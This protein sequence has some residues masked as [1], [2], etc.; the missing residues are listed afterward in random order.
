MMKTKLA[1]LLATLAAAFLIGGAHPPKAHAY[2]CTGAYSH[3]IVIAME[4]H[5]RSE[6]FG[7]GNA[8]YLDSLAAQYA[9]FSNY[10]N[11]IHP[12]L[13]NYL[14]VTGGTTGGI[15]SDCLPSQC[16]A[17]NQNNIFH[18]LNA[19]PNLT[20]PWRVEAESMPSNCYKTDSGN[21]YPKHNP[22]VYYTDLGNCST[23]DVPLNTSSPDF[24]AAL[25]WITPNICHDMH[26]TCGGN[27]VTNGDNWLKNVMM[28]AVFASRQWKAGDTLVVIWWDEDDTAHTNP[29]PMLAISPYATAGY[30]DTGSYNHYDMLW[31]I[32]AELGEPC[33]NLDCNQTNFNPNAGF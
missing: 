10:Q 24:T 18:V 14:A 17:Q 31:N 28:P 16:P 21:Y 22:A 32:E 6:V 9:T 27:A 8:P 11:L 5:D 13:P 1:A 3:V 2:C 25:T 20:N 7:S 19:D 4:N 33:L 26:D 15:T 30:V 23:K 29:L 12:S